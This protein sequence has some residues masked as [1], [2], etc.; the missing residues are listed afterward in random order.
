MSDIDPKIE[1]TDPLQPMREKIDEI[2]AKIVSLLTERY[3]QVHE[4][5][6]Y[7]LAHN[8]SIYIPERE[9]MVMDR[10]LGHNTTGR[11][12]P[13]ILA[14]IYREVMSGALALEKP[15]SVAFM[16][17][18]ASYSQQ[19]ATSRFGRSVRYVE[20][21]S[22]MEV[23]AEVENGRVDYGCVPVENSAEGVVN[24]TLD[25]LIASETKICAEINARI[26]H[27]LMSRCAPEEIKVIYSHQQVFG[28]CRQWL[29]KNFPHAE[30]VEV[31]STSLAAQLAQDEPNSAAIASKLAS[32]IYDIPIRVEGV[33]DSP[34]NT[35]RFLVLGNHEPKATGEDKTSICFG[36]KDRVGALYDALLPFRDAQVTMTMIESRPSKRRNWEYLFFIDLLG[37]VSEPRIAELLEKLSKQCLFVRV[38]GS[39]PCALTYN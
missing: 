27:N 6:Q 16:G 15:L 32:E 30:L 11:I 14:A 35:T 18:P 8:Q 19:A 2:D 3:A 9:K 38:L 1:Y 28:Q 26:R 12:P 7:K 36:L 17:P 22:I 31:T 25:T 24:C 37:H 34:T 21:P 39:Y 33:E 5:G 23:F 13:S 20:L 10:I 4:I 29:L